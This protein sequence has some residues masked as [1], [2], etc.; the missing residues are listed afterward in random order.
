MAITSALT[1]PVSHLI[2]RNYIGETLSWE[3]AGY[4]QAIWYISAMYLMV[5]TTTLSVYYLPKLSEITDNAELR[6]ELWQGCKIIMPVVIAMS[7][8]IFVLKDFTIW[9]LFTE[10]FIPIRQLFLWQLVGDV[11]KISAWLLAYLMIAKAM[12]KV[13]IITEIAFNFNFVLLSIW[14]VDQFGLVGMSYAFAVNY[15][16]YLVVMVFV[17]KKAWL[18]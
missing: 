3:D 13:F 14:S 5:V 4:W 2:V 7:V 10:E 18:D 15:A 16:V 6:K 1:V 17:T 8:G 9:L 11:F 12:T